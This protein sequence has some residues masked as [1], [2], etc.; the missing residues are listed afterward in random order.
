VNHMT[1][2]TYRSRLIPYE[3]EIIALRRKKPPMPY[4]KIAELLR[5]KYQI[6]IRQENII[7]FI[8]VRSKG[9]KTCKYAWDYE[10][11]NE[12]NKPTTVTPSL[13]K[14]ATVTKPSVSDKP[15]QTDES[16]TFDM[17][18]SETY[19]L[20]RLTPEELAARR[21]KLEEKEKQ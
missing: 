3:A 19:N 9:Y 16:E 8:K 6:T 20:T 12:N 15:K 10:P 5:E 4:S 7:R 18:F 2:N 13:Q 1:Y 14:P 21:K 11:T 17:P